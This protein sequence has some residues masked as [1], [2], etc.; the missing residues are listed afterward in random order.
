MTYLRR[1]VLISAVAMLFAAISNANLGIIS[2]FASQNGNNWV[3]PL[4]IALVFLGSGIGA[5]YNGYIGKWQYRTVIFFGAMGWN[6]F[7]T[8]SVL[9][10]FVGF[11][12]LVVVII[13]AGSLVCGLMLST[14]YNGL[15]NYVNECGKRDDK[16]NGYFGLSI[17]IVECSNIIGKALSAAL[18][19]PLG[20]KTYS[21][22]MLSLN[23]L[24][25]LLYLLTKEFP[26]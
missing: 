5:L 3:G 18:I 15:N 16:A 25:S 2:Q 6:I 10:L 7:L 21:F 4:S 23:I 12:N 13:L 17:C 11:S 14:Y 26:E 1:V 8:F 22:V 9:F 20:Q 19:K 24:I